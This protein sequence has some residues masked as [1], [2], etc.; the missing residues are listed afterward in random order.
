MNNGLSFNAHLVALLFEF[1]WG[2][3][4]DWEGVEVHWDNGL[5]GGKEMLGGISGFTWSHSEAI[6]NWKESNV[7]L[8]ELIDELHVGED[9]GVSSMVESD[10]VVWNV[11]NKSYGISSCDLHTLWSDTGRWMIGM[12]HGDLAVSEILGSSLLHLGNEGWWDS[13]EEFEE[14]SSL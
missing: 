11:N 13:S 12:D 2:S 7:W 3:G 5:W 4:K 14:C 6:T 10:I 8:I 1:L 9:V